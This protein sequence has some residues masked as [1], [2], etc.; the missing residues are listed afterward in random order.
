MNLRLANASNGLA[1]PHDGVCFFQSQHAHH[2]KHGY[3]ADNAMPWDAVVALLKDGTVTV[4]DATR[5]DKRMTGA[6]KFGV[7]TW[8]LV[9]NRAV[10]R[11]GVRVCE[12]ETP[13]MRHVAMNGYHEHL[14][15]PI[16]RLAR[17]YARAGARPAVIG[18]NV[19][20]EC[21]SGF[22][23]DDDPEGLRQLVETESNFCL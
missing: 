22:V 16:R 1:F 7:P 2:M 5:K 17:V 4:V 9:Y 18:K 13:E 3:F 10:R 23:A 11:L 20:L 6:L 19:I 21:H 12:W 14:L 8:C 15:G